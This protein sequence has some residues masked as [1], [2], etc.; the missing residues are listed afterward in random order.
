MSNYENDS[1]FLLMRLDINQRRARA[2]IFLKLDDYLKSHPQ[3]LDQL[4]GSL[5]RNKPWLGRDPL[6]IPN[7]VLNFL[8]L[9]SFSYV[10]WRIELNDM[11]S[12]LGVIPNANMLKGG[13]YAPISYDYDVLNAQLAGLAR[14][15]ADTELSASTILKYAS[16]LLRLAELEIY[17]SGH[18]AESAPT[19]MSTETREEIQS[20]IQRAEL[21]LTNIKMVNDVLQSMKAVLYNCISKHDSES[22]K[23]IAVVTLFFLPVTFVSTI[24]STGIFNFHATE[25]DQLQVVS[26]YGWLYLLLYILS[27]CITLILWVC[28]Y[29]WGSLWLEKLRL[30]RVHLGQKRPLQAL[31]MRRSPRKPASPSITES[32]GDDRGK[33]NPLASSNMHQV[34]PMNVAVDTSNRAEPD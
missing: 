24:F 30:T 7:A 17:A 14:K 22:M 11:E 27:T 6:L 21:F 10:K 20:T 4:V 29:R 31:P 16:G 1:F 25:G 13:G 2:L 18:R 19:K 32:K 34:L 28:W 3:S 33:G 12:R 9:Q 8:Q 26:S 5:E 23:T 15:I